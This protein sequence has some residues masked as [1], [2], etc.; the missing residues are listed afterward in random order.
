MLTFIYCNSG[1]V[2]SREEGKALADAIGELAFPMF[3][4]RKRSIVTKI[5]PGL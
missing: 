5:L 3:M 2:G 1:L 4:T